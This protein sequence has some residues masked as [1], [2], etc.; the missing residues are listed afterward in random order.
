MTYNKKQEFIKVALT[1]YQT[2]VVKF[3]TI[4]LIVITA[5]EISSKL[6][7]IKRAH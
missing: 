6:K 4:I 3:S 5:S 2:F 7:I 1:G